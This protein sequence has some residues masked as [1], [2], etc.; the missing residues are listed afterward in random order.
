M[1][2]QGAVSNIAIF[3]AHLPICPLL[4]ALVHLPKARWGNGLLNNG[5]LIK[6]AWAN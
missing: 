6:W 4:I 5:C 3:I 1:A 2:W